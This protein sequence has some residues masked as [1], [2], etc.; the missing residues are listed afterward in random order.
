M[1]DSYRLRDKE[2]GEDLLKGFMTGGQY[3]GIELPVNDFIVKTATLRG[4]S[5]ITELI[6]LI[7]IIISIF[8]N[9]VSVC[10]ASFKI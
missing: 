2:F 10:R 4:R 5:K 3:I 1:F 8:K 9:G 7:G 6:L